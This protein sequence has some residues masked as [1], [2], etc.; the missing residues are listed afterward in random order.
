MGKRDRQKSMKKGLRPE[1]ENEARGDKQIQ[2]EL[3][4]ASFP[5]VEM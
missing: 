2:R 1:G 3:G 5:G 4:P